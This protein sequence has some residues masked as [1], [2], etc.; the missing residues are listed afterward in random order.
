MVSSW[1]GEPTEVRGGKARRYFRVEPAGII[2]LH[3]SRAR[4]LSMWD[5]LEADL[6][7]VTGE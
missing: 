5:G 4:L 7:G 3:E 1:L 2:A 6:D